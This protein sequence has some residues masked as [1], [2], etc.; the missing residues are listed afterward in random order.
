MVGHLAWYKSTTVA[1]PLGQLVDVFKI[2]ELYLSD[3]VYAVLDP[4]CFKVT[5]LIIL[6]K[7]SSPVI[8][9]YV[10]KACQLL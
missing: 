4:R 3:T 9:M 6:F 10:I 7:K 1:V 2:K 5:L 8:L